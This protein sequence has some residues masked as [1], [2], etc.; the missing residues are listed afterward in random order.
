MASTQPRKAFFDHE[1]PE[2]APHEGGWYVYRNPQK[3]TRQDEMT[4]DTIEYWT[5]EATWQE[6]D[7][8][9]K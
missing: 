7:P 6:K 1:P 9:I 3:L 8:T 2:F 4:L 5:A